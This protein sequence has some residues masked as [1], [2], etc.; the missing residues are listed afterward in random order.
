MGYLQIL[1][2]ASVGRLQRRVCYPR[3]R[4]SL[5]ERRWQ[6]HQC[7]RFAHGI[8]DRTIANV[9][10]SSPFAGAGK[11]QGEVVEVQ[12]ATSTGGGEDF[13]EQVAEA[14]PV[15]KVIVKLA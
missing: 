8:A 6:R 3:K 11:D 9:I 5:A 12:A 4:R 15:Q 2:D 13:V 14:L 1:E 10:R 7:H